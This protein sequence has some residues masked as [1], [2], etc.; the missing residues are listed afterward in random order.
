MSKDILN[1]EGFLSEQTPAIPYKGKGFEF[2]MFNKTFK[3][4]IFDKKVKKESLFAPVEVCNSSP[5]ANWLCNN[6]GKNY[7]SD[8]NDYLKD[9]NT[10][11]NC[12]GCRQNF[13]KSSMSEREGV[14]AVCSWKYDLEK[15]KK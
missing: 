3:F 2:T 9:I 5:V 4:L 14:C 15:L 8:M 12:S 11:Y 6:K 13:Q 10:I 1:T 7:S